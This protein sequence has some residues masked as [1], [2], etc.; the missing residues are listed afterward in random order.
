MKALQFNEAGELIILP[1]ATSSSNDFDFY[2]GKWNVRNKK[3]KTRLNN[4]NEWTAFDATAQMHKILNGTANHESIFANLDG[5]PFEGLAVRLFHPQTKLWTIY[6]ADS[7]SCV[8][9][10]PVVGSFDGPVGEFFAKDTFNG[11]DIIM[12][13]R[14]DA[15]DP[16]NLV[17][18]QAF[19]PDNGQTWEWNWYMY[20]SKAA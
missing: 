19:S 5:Q 7:K 2:V 6:W 17:W 1:S 10:T 9:D 8:M 20:M 3:L 13:Y 18:S 12:L 11:K 16:E 4:C 15:T 14:W